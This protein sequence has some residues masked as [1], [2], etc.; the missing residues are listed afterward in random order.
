MNGLSDWRRT[1]NGWVILIDEMALD[2]LNRQTRFT[3][4]TSTDNHQFVFSQELVRAEV[5]SMIGR[6]IE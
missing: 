5:I 6:G 4:T 3:D 1:F 2:Q